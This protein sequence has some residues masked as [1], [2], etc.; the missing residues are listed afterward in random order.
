[1]P[2]CPSCGSISRPNILM[3]NDWNWLEYRTAGQIDRLRLWLRELK[4]V[5]IIEL[6]AGENIPTVRR[7]GHQQRGP[8]IRINPRDPFL[9]AER[10]GVSIPRGGLE[11]LRGI[12][13]ALRQSGFL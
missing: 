2:R 9:S 8:L 5:V 13:T 12:E 11:A 10:K 1:M 7:F 3:F 4:D 6:G